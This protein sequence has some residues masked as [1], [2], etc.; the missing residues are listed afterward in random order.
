MTEVNL[1]LSN[2]SATL[3]AAP[4]TDYTLFLVI[5]VVSI[6]LLVLSR[7]VNTNDIVGRMITGV[8]SFILSAAALWGSLSVAALYYVSSA[9]MVENVT[10]NVT[11]TSATSVSVIPVIQ[12]LSAN[13]ITLIIAIFSIISLV[14]ILDLIITTIQN[15]RKEKKDENRFNGY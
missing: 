11:T 3:I 14:N 6:V 10:G 8:M 12:S 5:F 15:I 2:A 4:Y 13:W 1:T 9:A 7:C